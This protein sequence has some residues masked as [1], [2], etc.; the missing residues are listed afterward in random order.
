MS[1][2][3][4]WLLYSL[5]VIATS[6]GPSSCRSQ[7]TSSYPVS[8]IHNQYRLSQAASVGS[9]V[10][11][12]LDTDLR[13]S[14][15]SAQLARMVSQDSWLPL[16][17]PSESSFS[18]LEPKDFR[19][20]RGSQ[21][22]LTLLWIL[23]RDNSE[24]KAGN[25]T[26]LYVSHLTSRGWDTDYFAFDTLAFE[27]GSSIHSPP[28]L[29]VYGNMHILMRE[30]GQ[31]HRLFY[32]R[33]RDRRILL[34]QLSEHVSAATL[35]LS[36]SASP[37]VSFLAPAALGGEHIY[38]S[39]SVHVIKSID[40]GE[41]WGSPILVSRS[42]HNQATMPQMIQGRDGLTIIWGKN[43]HRGLF[44]HAI[45]YSIS[46]DDGENWSTPSELYN[47]NDLINDLIMFQ[48]PCNTLRVIVT[49]HTSSS[50][51][52]L[53]GLVQRRGAWSGLSLLKGSSTSPYI[54]RQN[55]AIMLFMRSFEP[56][57]GMRLSYSYL[58]R[59]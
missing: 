40:G 1:F 28:V 51:Y 45:W 4:V 41:S 24:I 25:S 42:G 22:H 10:Y 36:D 18:P 33:V 27:W 3:Q 39:N 23:S 21:D 29:D 15:P 2:L 12:L 16:T 34:H 32:L 9:S 43:L 58:R 6:S 44:P 7:W 38:D 52:G 17:L 50:E 48:D 47:G 20:V 30:I 37:Y 53:F 5:S 13:G 8:L 46:M 11:L 54:I 57:F 19:M 14:T 26:A 59:K 56:G 31:P 49:R 35:H 55:G